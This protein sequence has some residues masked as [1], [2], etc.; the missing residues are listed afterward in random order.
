M[1]QK[2][3]KII[4]LLS[5]VII[6]SFGISTLFSIYSL[7][8]LISE[9]NKEKSIVYANE[10]TSTVNSIFSEPRAV[11]MSINNTFV[12]DYILHTK[13]HTEEEISE[14]FKKYLSRTVKYFNYDTAFI[15][16]C[17]NL[18]Y[19]TE[20]GLSKIINFDNPDDD[21][22]EAFRDSNETYELNVDNDQ[23]NGNRTTIYINVRMENS[24]KEFLGAC[25]VGLTM[26]EISKEISRFETIKGYNVML[27]SKN[28]KIQVSSKTNYKKGSLSKNSQNI[29][30]KVSDDIQ[31]IID[32]YDESKNYQYIQREKNSFYII[33]YIK[34]CNWYLVIDYSEKSLP[35]ASSLL[36]KNIIACVISLLLLLIITNLITNKFQNRINEFKLKSEI[37]KMTGLFNRH[38]FE[39]KKRILYGKKSL[40]DIT[41]AVL[42]VNSLKFV[43]DNI[44]HNAGDELIKGAGKIIEEFF[45]KY[46]TSYR[47]GGDEFVVIIEKPFEN[48][49]EKINDFKKIT[50]NWKGTFVKNL[51]ISIG[52]VSGNIYEYV[53]IDELI[54]IA[55]KKMY[56]DKRNY[57]KIIRKE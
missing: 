33:K 49:P 9:N 24:Q 36:I 52:I 30:K 51:S 25:G 15:A 40:S 1:K 47:T 57:Y 43:N 20:Y 28:G 55:D 53:T 27:V 7:N 50:S 26:D 39:D 21:W 29:F 48:I 44:G 18:H 5:F 54:E 34:E 41:V 3:G 4:I 56:E 23:E 6:L 32:N 10:I 11:A 42:D 35:N 37:D 31:N 12:Q 2:K 19:Y 45:R 22:Y 13:T 14:T 17:S 38:T 8:T 46:G 16:P